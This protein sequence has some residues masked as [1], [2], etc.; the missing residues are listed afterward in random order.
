[1]KRIPV[2][3]LSLLYLASYAPYIVVTR[4]LA[5]TPSAQLGRPMTGL[6]ILP[7]TMII[8]GALTYAF[9]WAAGW[10]KDAHQLRVGPLS[11]PTF[12]RWTA[13]SGLCTAFILVTVP[14]S[15]TF[16]GVSIPFIQVLMRGDVLIVAP[17]VDI[18]TGRKVRWYSWVALGLAASG[19][20]L[21]LEARKGFHL[22]PL[23]IL[24]VVFYTLG[25]FGRLW[26]MTR[27]AKTGET[28]SV[29][30]YFVEEKVVGI[31]ASV[32]FLAVVA[33]MGLGTQR[34]ALSFGFVGIWGSDQL[35]WL[36]VLSVLLFIVSVISVL[37]LLDPRENTFCVPMERSASILATI[38]AA[39]WLAWQFHQPP[40]TGPE[41]IGAVL[42]VT[43]I[44]LLSLA[45]RFAPAPA[46]APP[47][48]A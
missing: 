15:F 39:Y 34:H 26:V 4:W 40:P 41:L 27:I 23:A 44:V 20:G 18:I 16:P 19:I 7:I 3:A 35:I 6:E 37:I 48:K 32:V 5:T 10:W 46:L 9:V 1:M 36:I 11:I 14:L 47:A 12:T 22:P 31:P 29:N 8:S 21:T 2:E 43:A 24:T 28:R 13:L 38:V 17:L 42:L 25:Y 45:P 33:A 30:A